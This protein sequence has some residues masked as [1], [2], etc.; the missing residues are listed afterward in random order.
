MKIQFPWRKKTAQSKFVE[1]EDLL[2]STLTPIAARQE[3]LDSL[4]HDLVGKKATTLFGKISPKTLRMGILGVGAALSGAFIMVAGVRWVFS[5]LA[6]LG[7]IQLH[8][9]KSSQPHTL[10]NQPA[11]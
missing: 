7:L 5:L 9:Q 4:R 8:R 11:L 3:Y 2:E 1:L 10:P 6:A